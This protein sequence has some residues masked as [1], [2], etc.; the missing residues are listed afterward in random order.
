MQQY[1]Q[2]PQR[3]I[4]INDKLTDERYKKKLIDD[5]E[6]DKKYQIS[7][8]YEEKIIEDIEIITLQYLSSKKIYIS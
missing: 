2:R 1:N 6:S 4:E 3:K 5:K 8:E 7:K